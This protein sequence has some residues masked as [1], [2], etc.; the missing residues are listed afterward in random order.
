V[1]QIRIQRKRRRAG[2]PWLLGLLV[3]IVLPLPF[4]LDQDGTPVGRDRTA[5]RDASAVRDT[6]V[7]DTTPRRDTASRVTGVAAG[8]V[9]PASG[10]PPSTVAGS[11]RP[12]TAPQREGPFERFIAR[13]R[14][15]PDEGAQRRYTADALRRLADELR[16]RD[17]SEAGV[18]A[19]R[20]HADSL[21]TAPVQG[22]ARAEHARAAFLAVVR[23]IDLLRERH[24]AAADTGRLRSAAW[25]IRPRR[26]LLAQREQVQ[27]FFETARDALHLLPRRR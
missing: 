19:I 23:E 26:G 10:S 6:T 15:A 20:M 9:A 25:A 11:S 27:G 17:A 22:D 18:A 12:A 1:A 4:L 2:W 24:A 16:A 14:R 7:R 3:L 13:S 5:R 8:A 21:R